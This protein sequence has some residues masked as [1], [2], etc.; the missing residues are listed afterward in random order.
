[1]LIFDLQLA[2]SEH[3]L[4]DRESQLYEKKKLA[5]PKNVIR[6]G[7]NALIA[8]SGV[9]SFYSSLLHSLYTAAVGLKSPLS[10]EEH[11]A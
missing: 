8:F 11:L 2:E 1:M 7:K 5:L 6:T 9:S 4:I 10:G 3:R